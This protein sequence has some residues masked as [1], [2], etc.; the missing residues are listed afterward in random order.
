MLISFNLLNN[1]LINSLIKIKYFSETKIRI[2]I[3]NKEYFYCGNYMCGYQLFNP[4]SSHNYLKCFPITR[5]SNSYCKI[6]KSQI[7]KLRDINKIHISP[8]YSFYS[9]FIC[10][11][12]YKYL[13]IKEYYISGS[14]Y[15]INIP[16]SAKKF[17]C[18]D[19]YKIHSFI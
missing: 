17:N 6:E 7:I 12:Y 14:L 9:Y 16:S 13:N 8:F 3:N 4:S 5:G 15:I 19:L 18:R 10:N 2:I 11:K 1:R